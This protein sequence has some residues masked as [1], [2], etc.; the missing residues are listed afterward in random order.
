MPKNKSYLKFNQLPTS[1]VTKR[2]GVRNTVDTLLG[3]I[4]WSPSWRR[5]VFHPIGDTLYDAGCLLEIVDF[6]NIQMLERQL[7]K[8]MEEDVAE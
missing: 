4:R 8:Q 7:R 5:Y 2:W 6:I 3:E 1:G